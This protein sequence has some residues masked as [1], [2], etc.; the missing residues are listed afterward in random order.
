MLQALSLAAPAKWWK[1]CY[2]AEAAQ[3]LEWE[4][5]SLAPALPQSSYVTPGKSPN[6]SGSQ[7]PHL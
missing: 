3:D 7:S 6:L 5:M 2:V 1:D 4:A